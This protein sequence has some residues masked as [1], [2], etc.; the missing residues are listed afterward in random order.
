[1]ASTPEKTVRLV[2]VLL[3]VGLL[4][5]MARPR[6]LPPAP[7]V[8]SQRPD[9]VLITIDTLRA[10]AVGFAGNRRAATPVLDRLAGAG[11]V[12]PNAHAHNVL[13][14][15]SHT[16]ILTGL[17]PYQHGVRD[18]SGFRLAPSIPTL[19]TVL[20]AAGYGTGA[21]IGGFP[22]D[23][24]F[25]L[26]RGFDVYDCRLNRGSGAGGFASAERRGDQVVAAALAWWRQQRAKGRPR[27]LWVHLFDP[28]AP[29]DPPEPFRSRFAS[30]LYLGEVAA[31]DSFLAPLL[32]PFLDGNAA[33]APFVVVTADH[34]ESLGEHG[35][36]THGLFAYEATLKVPLV[37]WGRSVIP[38]RDLRP[39]R[40]IDIFPTVL[41]AAG[42]SLPAG[43]VRAYAG[44]SLLSPAAAAPEDSYF[45]AL[46]AALDRGWAPLRGVLHRGRKLISL[47]L[48]EV[49]DL[50]RDPREVHNLYGREHARAREVLLALPRE[51]SW[52]PRRQDLPPESLARLA[53]LGYLASAG[54]APVRFGPEDD[55]KRLIGLERQMHGVVELSSRGRLDAAVRLAR[56]V[57]AR[58]PQ[59]PIGQRMLAETLLAA[60]RTQ[61]ALAAM[62]AARRRG[63]A[64]PEL[65]RQL[66]LTLAQVGRT[67]EALAVLGPLAAGGSPQSLDALSLALSQAGRLRE[68][69]DVARRAIAAD[70]GDARAYQQMGMIELRLGRWNEAR[71][72]LRKAVEL[73]P[74]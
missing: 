15:P 64:S 30:N 54:G 49:Y 28:H 53:S 16:N 43:G 10:D 37:L 52:P 24:Q 12:F 27:F 32:G 31:A 29:Y 11:R 56:D 50:E 45:E 9:V 1:M 19:A 20:H 21:F 5:G 8:H 17:Y 42:V 4:L 36:L 23:A 39:A 68:A 62:E 61:E 73:S 13:T 41:Q 72:D 25:G 35:E 33:A 7:I 6:V 47:P 48:P 40:H 34:G 58:R 2:L 67:A 44:R 46:S 66:G 38:G 69:A 22:L 14:L 55:P 59:M 18:N 57:V 51:P 60:G 70:P 71:D 74:R 63:A 3:A 26:N 65:L